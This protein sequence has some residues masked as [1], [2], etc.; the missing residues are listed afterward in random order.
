MQKAGGKIR[1]TTQLINTEDGYH[2]WSKTFDRDL[3][4]IFSV[5][6][7]IA[8]AVASAL[9]KSLLGDREWSISTSNFEA[10]NAYLL[11][12]SYLNKATP[13]D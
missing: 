11:G 13:G 8:G 5:Q 10:Y 7:E 2:L 3:E 6:D 1:I 12:L 4:D 9:K